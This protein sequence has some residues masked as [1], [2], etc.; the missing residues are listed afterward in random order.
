MPDNSFEENCIRAYRWEEDDRSEQDFDET[1]K[2]PINFHFPC[3]KHENETIV[4]W[5]LDTK[6]N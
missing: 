6:W 3:N 5:L 2:C 1:L 4:E